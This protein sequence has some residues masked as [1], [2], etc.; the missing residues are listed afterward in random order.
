MTES[1]ELARASEQGATFRLTGS[2]DVGGKMAP[3]RHTADQ[4]G[5]GRGD[6]GYVVP[7]E[8]GSF[9]ALA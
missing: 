1:E 3:F 9:G 2:E 6:V 7:A 4:S 5:S 8:Q